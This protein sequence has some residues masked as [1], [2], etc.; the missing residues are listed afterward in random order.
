MGKD[1]SGKQVFLR[2]GYFEKDGV[3]QIQPIWWM[4]LDKSQYEKEI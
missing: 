3:K 4:K 1:S 2:D